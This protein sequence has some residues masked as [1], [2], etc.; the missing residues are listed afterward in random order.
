[1]WAIRTVTRAKANTVTYSYCQQPRARPASRIPRMCTWRAY[2]LRSCLVAS[3]RCASPHGQKGMA[4]LYWVHVRTAFAFFEFLSGI[5]SPS[6]SARRLRNVFLGCSRV[7]VLP[8]CASCALPPSGVRGGMQRCG[9][10]GRT[11]GGTDAARHG[12]E[13]DTIRGTRR[14]TWA[15]LELDRR[16]ADGASSTCRAALCGHCITSLRNGALHLFFFLTAPRAVSQG[17]AAWESAK[18]Q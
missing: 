5:V 9:G 11:E 16:R 1:M 2:A 12:G 4:S 15:D 14:R 13:R 18:L 7:G 8:V 6:G 10:G 17:A 3:R